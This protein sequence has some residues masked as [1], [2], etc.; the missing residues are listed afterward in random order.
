[1]EDVTLIKD[2]TLVSV[3]NMMD[4]SVAYKLDNGV[5]RHF[6]PHATIKG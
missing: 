4:H 2:N 5:R 6:A 3:T 1:M